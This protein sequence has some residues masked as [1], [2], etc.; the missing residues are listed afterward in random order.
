MDLNFDFKN[1]FILDIAN[2]HQGSVKHGKKIIEKHSEVIKKH[3]VN[4]ALKFQFRN[5]D[6]FIHKNFKGRK[7]FNSHT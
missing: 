4:G 3:G 5:L 1:L 6:T 2:N 7:N